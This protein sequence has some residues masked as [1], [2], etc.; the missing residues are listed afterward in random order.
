MAAVAGVVERG[1]RDRGRRPRRCGV[2]PA[3]TSTARR[4]SR[5][6]RPTDLEAQAAAEG[7]M[8][9]VRDMRAKNKG[10]FKAGLRQS[11]GINEVDQ[12]D[13]PARRAEVAASE[14]AAR[15]AARAPYRAADAVPVAF[16]RIATRGAHADR[17]AARPPGR[18]RLRARPRLRRLPRARPDQPAAD[19]RTPR[20]GGSSSG[21][22]CTRRRDRAPAPLARSRPRSSPR[23]SGS[24]GGSASRRC[25]TRT[26]R[27]RSAA[28][29]GIE[30]SAASAS[31]ACASSGRCS[32]DGD[33]RTASGPIRTL[34]NGVVA[35]HPEESPAAF[36]QLMARR[37]PRPPAGRR[38]GRPRRGPQ[39]GGRRP[40]GAPEDQPPALGP[41]AVPLPPVHAQRAAA[42]PTSRSS[43]SSRRTA[44]AR[45]PRSTRRCRWMQGGFMSTNLG[46]KQPCADGKERM[47]SHGCEHVVVAYRDSPSTPPGA[48]AGPRTSGRSSRRGC[49]TACGCARRSPC[50]DDL[51]EGV[52]TAVLRAAFRAADLI[53]RIEAWGV[54]TARA[55]PL[56]LAARRLMAVS[57]P[58]DP[59]GSRPS[60][61]RVGW[62]RVRARRA[63]RRRRDRG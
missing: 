52:P 18:F 31:R 60:A 2:R 41:L 37:A 40:R 22:S 49:A 33:A 12:I 28:R 44:T 47:R 8:S 45:R 39:L 7:V 35:I 51:T 13:D 6:G 11:F 57:Q 38:A 62:V 24:R 27:W 19:A 21:R 23:S 32:G 46:P 16:D 26:S 53:D 50:A 55:L 30:P 36:E 48:S 56:L 58:D 29:R 43:A 63:A 9:V 15:D 3:T 20:R 10:Q 42:P 61:R 1:A 34:V 17:R 4:W 25:S 14:R 59:F 54:E 5:R